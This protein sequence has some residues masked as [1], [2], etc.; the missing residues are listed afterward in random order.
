ML[1]EFRR[2][3][4]LSFIFIVIVILILAV[5]FAARAQ[6][7]APIFQAAVLYPSGAGG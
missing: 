3:S 1:C 7:T 2:N 6:V 5:A 4:S